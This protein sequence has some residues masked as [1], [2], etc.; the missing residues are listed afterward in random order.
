MVNVLDPNAL[1]S[2]TKQVQRTK[3][4]SIMVKANGLKPSTQYSAIYN[5][6]VVNQFCK[7]YGGNLGQQ[8]VST[9][10]GT[11]QFKYMMAVPYNQTYLVN[12]VSG[13]LEQNT[14]L[15]TSTATMQLQDPSGVSITTYIPINLMQA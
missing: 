11:I 13:N 10:S 1:S 9:D 3:Y 14:T 5:G 2:Q 6:V 7:P 15:S 12:N 8:L 4:F